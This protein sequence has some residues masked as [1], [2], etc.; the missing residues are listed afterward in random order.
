MNT[1]DWE[2]PIG[3]ERV[4][5]GETRRENR[6]LVTCGECGESRLLKRIDAK[7]VEQTDAPCYPCTQ[8]EK[9][10]LGYRATIERHG[11]NFF[12][13]LIRE[14]ELNN[15]PVLTRALMDILDNV[16]HIRYE[17]EIQCGRYLIDFVIGDRF[18]IEVN[19][20]VHV[21]HAERDARKAQ[22]LREQGYEL[23][24]LEQA[25]IPDA[26]DRVCEFLGVYELATV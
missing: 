13:D 20:G 26:A 6:F 19:G 8:R 16:L 14:R 3:F 5:K 12:L 10:K 2:H 15:P 25:D 11:E 4:V 24:V 21:L 9:G 1:V 17:R 7:K 18:A 22:F 23:L